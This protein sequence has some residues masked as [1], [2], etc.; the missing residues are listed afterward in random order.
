MF[1]NGFGTFNMMFSI[2]PIFFALVFILIFGTIIFNVVRGAGRWS[3]NNKQPVLSVPVKVVAKRS[4][5]T[6]NFHNNDMHH[7]NHTRT[8][9]YVTFEVESG[10]RMELYLDDSEYGLLVEGDTGKL[11]FQGTRYLGF[12]RSVSGD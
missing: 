9:Y 7:S 8:T 10:D 11:T 3:H 5:I 4:H 2:F 1:D 6:S 12:E